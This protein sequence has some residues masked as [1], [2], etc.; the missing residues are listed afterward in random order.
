VALP[1][2]DWGYAAVQSQ[3]GVL[4]GDGVIHDVANR[5]AISLPEQHIP[6]PDE[7]EATFDFNHVKEAR[8]QNSL[9][10]QCIH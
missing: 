9:L 7:T 3:E 1:G 8:T 5:H 2:Q 6:P 4:H 10:H